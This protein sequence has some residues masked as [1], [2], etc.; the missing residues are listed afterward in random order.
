MNQSPP[1]VPTVGEIARREG[2]PIHRVEYLI[3]ARGIRPVGRAGAAYIYSEVDADLI[4][5][6]LR[7]IRGE[8]E[9][10]RD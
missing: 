4:T 3:R 9:A 6:E 2:V 7:R 5:A 10:D 8:R 1:T